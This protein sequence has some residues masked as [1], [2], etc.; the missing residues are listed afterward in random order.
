V[1]HSLPLAHL[2]GIERAALALLNAVQ[3]AK[4]LSLSAPGSART[5]SL[6]EVC[7]EFLM[8]K[9]HAQRSEGYIRVTH[10]Q[11]SAVT[12]GLK[13]VPLA[14]ITAAQIETWLYNQ[15]WNAVTQRN[16][17]RTIR[18]VFQ[19]AVNRGLIVGNVAMG[20]DLPTVENEPPGI[21]TPEEVAIVL[22]TAR[23]LDVDLCR[24]LAVRYFAGLRGSEAA[25][26]SENEIQTDRGFIEVTAAKAKTR[27]RR[28]VT[29]QPA[30]RSWLDLGGTLPLGDVNTKRWRL[31]QA[32]EFEWPRNVTRHSFVSYHLA[33]FG[34]A[35][36]TALEAGH[37]EQMLFQ[38]YRELVTPDSAKEFW[39]IRPK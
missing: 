20:I 36:K 25:A 37:T 24:W 30:L 27:R 3:S 1:S 33:E 9:A 22:E 34:S 7:N 19:Y 6:V 14:S 17:L 21:H 32:I 35:A 12:K 4:G 15:P 29:I 5:P 16:V 28:L 31:T 8:S 38:H 2:D 23:S 11:L 18:T 10:T 39:A 26:I 13:D